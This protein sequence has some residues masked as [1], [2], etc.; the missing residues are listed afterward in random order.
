M[1]IP[2]FEPI[3][4][5][6][7]HL[8]LTESYD[9]NQQAQFLNVVIE[10]NTKDAFSIP[11]GIL[12]H[13]DFAQGKSELDPPPQLYTVYKQ[14]Q[15]IQTILSKM[16]P[17]TFE[18]HYKY[19]PFTDHPPNYIPIYDVT[20]VSSNSPPET[21]SQIKKPDHEY[22]YF[23]HKIIFTYCQ[24]STQEL[25]NLV[26]LLR[27]IQDVYSQHENDFSVRVYLFISHLNQ[28]PN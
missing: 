1:R 16:Y 21:S 7:N 22:Q 18:V 9:P 25:F 2:F 6:Y 26:Q 17:D 12:E 28:I 11:T 19:Y 13:I 4:Q 15:D 27:E 20:Q 8:I 23:L 14:L 3:Q 24:F 5:H 10:N